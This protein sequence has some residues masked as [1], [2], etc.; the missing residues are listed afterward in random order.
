MSWFTEDPTLLLVIGGL[1]IAALVVACA[2]TGRVVMIVWAVPVAAVVGGGVLIEHLVVTPREEVEGTIES[3]R[4]AFVA[5]DQEAVL[6]YISPSPA[7]DPIRRRIRWALQM[8][9]IREARITDG[10]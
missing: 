9:E 3:A 10:P 1:L 7:A 6:R 5:N 8:A 4:Q 2:K